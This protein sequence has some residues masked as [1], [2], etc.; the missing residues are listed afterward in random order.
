[1][2]EAWSVPK[3][4]VDPDEDRWAAARREFREELGLDITATPTRS[5]P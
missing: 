3:G 4:L 5:R 1:M 2:P